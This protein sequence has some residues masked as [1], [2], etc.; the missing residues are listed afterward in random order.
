MSQ[1]SEGM[2]EGIIA[3]ERVASG[4]GKRGPIVYYGWVC[5]AAAAL[6]MV[7]TLPGRTMGLGLVTEPLLR[8]L[9]LSRTTYGTINLWATLIGA[10]FGLGAGR[11]LAT[12]EV[13][14]R[15]WADGAATI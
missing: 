6:A 5:V 4:A 3:G 14:R 10:G 11:L 8:D 12:R 9:G 1:T 7:A 15:A 13:R 2:A